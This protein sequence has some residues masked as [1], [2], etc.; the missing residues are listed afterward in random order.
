MST[1]MIYKHMYMHM[2][3]CTHTCFQ[4][5][6]HMYVHLYVYVYTHDYTWIRSKACFSDEP[7]HC[8]SAQHHPSIIPCH[9]SIDW[10]CRHHPSIILA[11]G[12]AWAQMFENIA[13]LKN[14]RCQRYHP[15]GKV[16]TGMII[17]N[18]HE[19]AWVGGTYESKLAESRGLSP[20]RSLQGQGQG[21][22]QKIW[23]HL[24][25]IFLHFWYVFW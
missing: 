1:D 13:F 5:Y 19:H 12:L 10:E 4:I 20:P 17:L 22:Y 3:G 7:M 6:I 23:P 16:L 15:S 21:P 14:R 24:N 18:H 9:V 2:P 11:R 25:V 8:P